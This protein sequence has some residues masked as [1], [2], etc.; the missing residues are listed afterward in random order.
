MD[1]FVLVLQLALVLVYF[2]F[3]IKGFLWLVFCIRHKS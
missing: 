3:A 1:F 2:G